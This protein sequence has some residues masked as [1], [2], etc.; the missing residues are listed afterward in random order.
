MT[1]GS[2]E[3][4]GL[5]LPVKGTDSGHSSTSSSRDNAN[6]DEGTEGPYDPELIVAHFGGDRVAQADALVPGFRATVKRELAQALRS[7]SFEQR[8][9]RQL[10]AL[11]SPVRE[12]WP[13]ALIGVQERFE[14]IIQRTG[15][16]ARGS[17]ARRGEVL[18]SPLEWEAELARRL[19]LSPAT[20]LALEYV[21]IPRPDFSPPPSAVS[22]VWGRIRASVTSR[23]TEISDDAI[24]GAEEV[25]QGRLSATVRLVSCERAPAVVEGPYRGW[26][27]IGSYETRETVHADWNLP[28]SFTQRA[29]ALEA[30]ERDDFAGVNCPPLVRGDARWWS[31]AVGRAPADLRYPDGP[32]VGI[33]QESSV[34][35]IGGEQLGSADPLL[36]PTRQ[37]VAAAELEPDEGLSMNDANG[38]GLVLQTWR[39]SY[40]VGEYQLERPLLWGSWM[41]LSPSAFDRLR[42]AYPDRLVWR[43]FVSSTGTHETYS[44]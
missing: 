15:A 17:L 37:L 1:L 44:H 14:D 40:D 28:Q 26:R 21:R 33:D 2:T 32:L 10:R 41:L 27:V 18:A 43:E 16:A 29:C 13:N 30:R 36:I 35:S 34:L 3:Y 38:P 4:S 39:S 31:T 23:R 42:A 25:D 9:G 7:E 22:A 19:I 11:A 12:I 6:A 8:R 24:S 5:W 20:S